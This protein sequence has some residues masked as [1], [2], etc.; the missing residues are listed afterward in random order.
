MAT[1]FAIVRICIIVRRVTFF[2][3]NF[4]HC[5]K[6]KKI[7]AFFVL[8][9]CQMFALTFTCIYLAVC[10]SILHILLHQT[11]ALDLQSFSFCILE[12]VNN[13]CL[14]SICEYY[15]IL[16]ARFHAFNKLA[17]NMKCVLWFAFYPTFLS[18]LFWLMY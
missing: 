1:N 13:F 12:V 5:F 14:L 2:N 7:V 11:A 15:V 8:M 9:L 10:L 6:R 3:A 18:A 17:H 16:T 4:S